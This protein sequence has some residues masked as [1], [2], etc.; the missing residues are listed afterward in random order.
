M[1]TRGLYSVFNWLNI[2]GDELLLDFGA[3]FL[4]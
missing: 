1:V 3:K 4:R 2:I